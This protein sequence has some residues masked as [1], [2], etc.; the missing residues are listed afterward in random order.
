M[1]TRATITFLDNKVVA[2]FQ[3][4]QIIDSLNYSKHS[5]EKIVKQLNGFH[6]M[7]IKF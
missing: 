1:G 5:I 3:K 4:Y 2:S 7:Y 6:A